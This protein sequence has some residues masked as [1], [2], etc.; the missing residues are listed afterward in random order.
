[1]TA[2]PRHT[3]LDLIARALA[4]YPARIAL[5]GPGPARSVCP[6]EAAVAA[7]NK[8]GGGAEGAALFSAV[9]PRVLDRCQVLI[10]RL[11]TGAAVGA[12]CEGAAKE[13]EAAHRELAT[14]AFVLAGPANAVFL[15]PH[16]PQYAAVCDMIS[17]PA[18]R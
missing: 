4:A 18:L 2:A 8:G 3:P 16:A 6:I 12:R 17:D 1:M 9:T 5:P 13:V 7:Y 15:G 10:H 14:L 11:V